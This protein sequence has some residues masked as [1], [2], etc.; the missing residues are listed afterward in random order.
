MRRRLAVAAAVLAAAVIGLAVPATGIVDRLE[1]QAQD[2]RFTIRAAREISSP[3][4]PL[5]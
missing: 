1:G 3:A 2:T 5:G 4:S